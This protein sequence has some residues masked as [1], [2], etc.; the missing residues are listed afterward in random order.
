M[1]TF[2]IAEAGV[3]HNGS[4]ELAKQLVD[5]AL[6]AGAD[7]IKF[8]SFH[9]ENLVCFNAPKAEY[10]KTWTSIKESQYEMLKLLELSEQH[11][12][13]LHQY[14]KKNS[15]LFLSS[16]FDL[17][18]IDFLNHSLN[19]PLFKIPSGEITNYPL[20]IKIARTGKKSILSTGMSTLG[21]IESALSIL[22]F[23]Y[24]YQSETINPSKASSEEIYYSEQGQKILR[25]N[26]S[27]LHCTS[28][29][30]A[31]FEETNLRVIQTLH[32]AFGLPIGYS[33][34]TLGIAVAIAAVA[35]GATIIEKH[36]TLSKSMS[37]PDHQASLEPHELT[38]MIK[39]IR[40]VEL[41]LGNSLKIPTKSELKNRVIARKS[42]VSL[43]NIK[44]GDLFTEKTIGCKRPGNGV[45]PKE[46]YD[47]KDKCA[48]RD[49]EKDELIGI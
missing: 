34:H 24:L 35:S 10:Q 44:K 46:F 30:P 4:L 14:C 16:P 25:E 8:Q 29:Y 33:D 17:S 39:G 1:K 42:L 37:G 32:H 43:E 9:A 28:E 26:V 13:E 40:Q 15:I 48:E 11:Q 45:S 23:G 31:P 19:L 47:Y 7:A 2:I 27:L 12:I 49:Y 21:E 38:S 5:V 3:N 22:A 18:S 20:L 36:F 41:A 6:E